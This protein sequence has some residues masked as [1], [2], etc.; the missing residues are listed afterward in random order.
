MKVSRY[1]TSGIIL[2]LLLLFLFSNCTYERT[3]RQ[4]EL[5]KLG[6][7]LR[8]VIIDESHPGPLYDITLQEDG[9]YLLG[10]VI[11][12]DDPD[13]LKQTGIPL[14]ATGGGRATARLTKDQVREVVRIR[15][16][17]YIELATTSRPPD[18]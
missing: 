1:L 18:E 16:V 4:S 2:T 15:G 12:T 17:Q 5:R 14:L 13:R 3:L 11:R 10:V 8:S 9:T 7:V 6:P